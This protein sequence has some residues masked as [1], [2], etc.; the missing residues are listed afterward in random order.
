M[1]NP[2]RRYELLL[3][4]SFN[5]GSAVSDELIGNVLREIRK[6]FGAVSAETQRIEGQ[7]EF[8]GTVYRDLN[9]RIYVDVPDIET[10]R[11]FFI[12]LKESLKERFQQLDIWMTTYPLEVI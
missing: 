8:E 9:V 6:R 4:T 11:Q 12:E 10:N 2:Y 1:P 5:D 3:P 7:W